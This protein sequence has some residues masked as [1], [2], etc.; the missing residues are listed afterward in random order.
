MEAKPIKAIKPKSTEIG[1]ETLPFDG[2][3][4]VL[5]N[6]THLHDPQI[7]LIICPK[8]SEPNYHRHKPSQSFIFGICTGSKNYPF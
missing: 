7:L 6:A 4:H 3:V 2:N 1:I 8:F 5:A